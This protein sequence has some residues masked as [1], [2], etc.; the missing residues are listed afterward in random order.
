VCCCK[1]DIRLGKAQ[2]VKHDVLDQLKATERLL[3]GPVG[4]VD[5]TVNVFEGT[6]DKLRMWKK[7]GSWGW[8]GGRG[9]GGGMYVG[10]VV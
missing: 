2:Q 7:V 3:T 8:E 6:P 10:G 4:G 5:A 9:G 1:R